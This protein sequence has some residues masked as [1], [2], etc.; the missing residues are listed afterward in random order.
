MVELEEPAVPVEVDVPEALEDGPAELAAGGELAI[1][2]PELGAEAAGLAE[3]SARAGE[4][5][6]DRSAAIVTALPMVRAVFKRGPPDIR[7]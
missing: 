5:M 2:E 1:D 3:P 6:S 4:L 7:G